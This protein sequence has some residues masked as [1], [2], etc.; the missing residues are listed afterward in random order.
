LNLISELYDTIFSVTKTLGKEID[1]SK[2]KIVDRGV[3]HR[4]RSLMLGTMG[5]YMFLY[6]DRFLKIGKVGLKSNAR[7]LSQHYNPH[8]SQ[9]NLAA[10]ILCDTEMV[11]NGITE[12]TVSTWI[13]TN[14]R[15]IDILLDSSLG[16][17]TLELLEAILHYKY[18]PKYE[19]FST[20]L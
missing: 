16:Y 1:M 5:I 4:P 15:R 9:S 19:G 2:V 12:G 10:S 18:E 17:F 8:S 7:F 20:Q 11:S 13:R 14:C 6:D 3:P